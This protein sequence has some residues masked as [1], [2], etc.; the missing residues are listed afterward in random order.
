MS[1][2]EKLSTVIVDTYMMGTLTGDVFMEL[3][4]IFQNAASDMGA[5]EIKDINN[6]ALR[7]LVDRGFVTASYNHDNRFEGYVPSERAW[8]CMYLQLANGWRVY[9]P[10]DA[11]NARLVARVPE[12]IETQS[13]LGRAV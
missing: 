11:H 4:A 3:Q 5:T 9:E 2:R 1:S 8:S 12:W 13:G 7:V 10:R 6:A